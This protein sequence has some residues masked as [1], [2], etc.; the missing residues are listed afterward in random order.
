MSVTGTLVPGSSTGSL[1]MAQRWQETLEDAVADKLTY[2]SVVRDVGRILNQLNIRKVARS[3][4]QSLSSTAHGDALTYG[5]SADTA[6]TIT[7][8]GYYHGTAFSENQIA[9]LDLTPDAPFRTLSENMVA[10]AIDSLSL[11][12]TASLTNT[13]SSAFAN[14]IDGST[15][16]NALSVLRNNARSMADPG[17]ADIH[18]VVDATRLQDLYAIAEF[19]HAHILGVSNGPQRNGI[20]VE[21]CGVTLHTTAQVYK[22]NGGTN[23]PFFIPSALGVGY[24]QRPMVRIETVEL[25][26]RVICYVNFGHGIIHDVRAMNVKAPSTL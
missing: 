17:K 22:A 21:A 10:E 15:F 9:Q 25:N 2:A 13:G 1:L 24:N 14:V 18:L 7:P 11:V 19:T 3:A 26:H 4:A 12:D 6:A 20:L 5:G 16:R 23:N 8:V